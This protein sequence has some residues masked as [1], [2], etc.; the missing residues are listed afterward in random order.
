[1]WIESP[2]FTQDSGLYLIVIPRC[3]YTILNATLCTDIHCLRTPTQERFTA[4]LTLPSGFNAAPVLEDVRHELLNPSVG[5]GNE[6]RVGPVETTPGLFALDLSRLSECGARQCE[7][8]D[9]EDWLCVMV[10]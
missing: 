8:D 2:H 10:R 4:F 1:M 3:L 7:V 9:E 6:C 5:G